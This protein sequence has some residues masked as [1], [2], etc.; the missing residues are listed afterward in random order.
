MLYVLIL[1]YLSII[2]QHRLEV[3]QSFAETPK[4]T[5]YKRSDTNVALPRS[6]SY[7]VRHMGMP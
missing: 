6:G 3:K 5:T 1:Y 7:K 4:S 2:T